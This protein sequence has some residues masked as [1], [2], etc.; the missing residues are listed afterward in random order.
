MNGAGEQW[1]RRGRQAGRQAGRERPGRGSPATGHC[2]PGDQLHRNAEGMADDGQ[3]KK[4]HRTQEGPGT[5]P[6]GE[7]DERRAWVRAQR[8]NTNREAAEQAGQPQ[9]GGYVLGGRAGAGGGPRPWEE[10]PFPFPKSPAP[11][12]L[13]SAPSECSRRPGAA[14]LPCKAGLRSTNTEPVTAPKARNNGLRPSQE[15]SPLI[16]TLA[17]VCRTDFPCQ[18]ELQVVDAAT[19]L[20][21]SKWPDHGAQSLHSSRRVTIFKATMLSKKC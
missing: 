13:V 5:Q 8:R 16:K 10:K 20:P 17:P 18:S 11:V 1:V 4:T 14:R 6:R 7:L 3:G 12:A 9:P 15:S 19:A 2:S 21:Y